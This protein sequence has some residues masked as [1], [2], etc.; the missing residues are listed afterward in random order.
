MRKDEVSIG[1]RPTGKAV[2]QRQEREFI[3]VEGVRR[4]KGE[5]RTEAESP[6]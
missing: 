2:A 3:G 5:E 6:A 1:N 4:Q